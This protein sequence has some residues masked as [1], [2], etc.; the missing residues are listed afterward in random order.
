MLFEVA[1]FV[2][3]AGQNFTQTI[4]ILMRLQTVI[5]FSYRKLIVF[6]VGRLIA[7]HVFIKSQN[8]FL[9]NKLTDS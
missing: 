6:R 9:R 5:Q 2:L 7:F 1:V 8:V 3:L 4:S